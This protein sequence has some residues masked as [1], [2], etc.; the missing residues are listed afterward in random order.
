[1]GSDATEMAPGMLEAGQT[2]DAPAGGDAN[3][4]GVDD[5]ARE[6]TQGETQRASWDEMWVT[7]R[8]GQMLP[9]GT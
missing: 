5:R 7:A 1:M 9:A 4:T 6:S 2:P 3:A 8:T